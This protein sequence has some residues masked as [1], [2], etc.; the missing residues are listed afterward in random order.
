MKKLILSLVFILAAGTTFMNANNE[1]LELEQRSPSDCVSSSRAAVE[2]IADAYNWDIHNGGAQSDFA[3][4]VFMI[5]Y[6]DCLG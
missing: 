1:V 2:A 5:I 6:T 3:V 4:E